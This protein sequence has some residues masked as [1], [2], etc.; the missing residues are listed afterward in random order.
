[1][2]LFISAGTRYASPPVFKVEAQENG[3]LLHLLFRHIFTQ[4]LALTAR[5]V[6][7]IAV[8]PAAEVFLFQK[9]QIGIAFSVRCLKSYLSLLI[10]A[11]DYS[12]QFITPDAPTTADEMNFQNRAVL[13]NITIAVNT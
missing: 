5:T 3:S 6:K 4:Y 1:M 12:G 13:R 9:H 10:A 11:E 7:T 2:K 8:F